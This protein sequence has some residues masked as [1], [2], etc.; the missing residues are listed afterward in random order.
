M[1]ARLLLAS[2]LLSG[3]AHGAPKSAI[4]W[5][6]E[7][8]ETPPETL[9]TQEET[10][11]NPN[12]TTIVETALDDPVRDGLGI[13]PP[14]LT[15]FP[16][17]LWAGTSLP[18]A[19]YLLDRVEL[20]GPPSVRALFLRLL[21]AE[22]DPP[23]GATDASGFLL[24]RIDRLMALGALEQA[25]ALIE[26][27]QPDT[28]PLFR[29]WFDIA[30]LTGRAD[31]ACAAL[32]KSPMMAP[33]GK[34]RIFCLTRTGDWDAAQIALNAAAD[35]GTLTEDE[36]TLFFMYVDPALAEALEAPPPSAPMQSLEFVMRGAIGLPVPRH[37]LPPAFLHT[38]LA[39]YIPIRYRI[40]SAERLGA[41]GVIDGTVLFAAYREEEPAASGSPWDR[42]AAVQAFDAALLAEDLGPHLEAL[43][44]ELHPRGL[45]ALAALDVAPRLTTYAS[46]EVPPAWHDL[47]AT[48][49]ILG[50]RADAARDWISEET[51]PD[52][53]RAAAIAA[54]D[55]GPSDG[56]ALTAVFATETPATLASQEFRALHDR[57]RIGEALL[58]AIAR[59]AT[60]ERMETDDAAKA[61]AGLR[62]LGLETVARDIAVERLLLPLVLVR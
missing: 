46:A 62:V 26:R 61:L 52:I 12:A 18:S 56:N 7:S 8:L 5:L 55:Q 44:T 42:A 10:P 17:D 48:Y 40:L 20:A 2:T 50:G 13:L 45:R 35:L 41:S 39:S 27:A 43:D 19:T 4:P 15:G 25:E 1:L 29:R 58:E 28:E 22:T 49:L 47:V 11:S 60:D 16:R 31:L 59:L 38:D 53:K 30:L 37:R 32:E 54:G 33:T 14:D 23:F 57:G 36:A 51:R 21:L 3:A 24:Y 6:T 9:E 34:V